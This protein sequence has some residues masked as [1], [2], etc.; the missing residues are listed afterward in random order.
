MS[1]CKDRD[2]DRERPTSASSPRC[3]AVLSSAAEAG[4]SPQMTTVNVASGGKGLVP[5]TLEAQL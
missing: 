2:W 3:L 1:D 4:R 5:S